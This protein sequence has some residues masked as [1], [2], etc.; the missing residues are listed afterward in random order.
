MDYFM[1]N[2]NC[3]SDMICKVT[4]YLKTDDDNF[5]KKSCKSIH[6]IL[7][8]VVDCSKQSFDDISDRI[9]EV[10]D[11]NLYDSNC[12][13][14]LFNCS[15]EHIKTLSNSLKGRKHLGCYVYCDDDFIPLMLDL[16]S[17]D[18]LSCLTHEL[19]R[20]VSV[21]LPSFNEPRS[22]NRYSVASSTY[23]PD[24]YSWVT[25]IPSYMWRNAHHYRG[26][27]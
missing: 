1:L 20:M 13:I 5:H 3:T 11:N 4:E 12:Y 19:N 18:K 25:G 2:V 22:Y 8:I 6:D 23:V 14:Y 21:Y 10:L 17:D 27:C 16:K 15:V 9:I 7:C 26:S 24:S